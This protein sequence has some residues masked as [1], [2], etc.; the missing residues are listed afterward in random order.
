M[1]E[2]VPYIL[3]IIGWAQEAPKEG[4]LI[5]H[6]LFASEEACRAEGSEYVAQ[7]KIYA[8]E[9]NNARFEFFCVPAPTQSDIETMRE[10]GE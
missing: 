3:V 4:L 10:K 1:I 2:I 8:K 9:F 7:R 5:E 6:R